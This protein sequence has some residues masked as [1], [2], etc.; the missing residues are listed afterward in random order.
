MS[1]EAD[2]R[3]LDRM[4]QTR[5]RANKSTGMDSNAGLPHNTGIRGAREPSSSLVNATSSGQSTW[6]SVSSTATA[7]IQR[8]HRG[9]IRVCRSRCRSHPEG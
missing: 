9:G 2:L 5:F 4:Q 1:A 3:V 6:T 8:P 7:L